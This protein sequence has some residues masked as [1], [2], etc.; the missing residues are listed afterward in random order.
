MP[1]QIIISDPELNGFTA[2]GRVDLVASITTYKVD[3]L[4]EIGRI[5][6]GQNA[7]SGV[8]EITSTMVK[9]AELVF[10]RGKIFQAKKQGTKILKVSAVLSLFIAGAMVQKE[11]LKEFSYLIAFLVVLVI[12]VTTNIFAHLRD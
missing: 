2:Q 4:K 10:G 8:A 3:L 12:A 9:E 6:A 5:E 1:E 11:Q 7:G